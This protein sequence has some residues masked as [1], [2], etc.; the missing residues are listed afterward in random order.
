MPGGHL[1]LDLTA[2][3]RRTTPRISVIKTIT[4]ILGPKRQAKSKMKFESVLMYLF[5]K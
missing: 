2:G 1:E 3:S 5:R 4:I